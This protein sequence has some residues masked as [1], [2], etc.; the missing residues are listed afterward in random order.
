MQNKKELVSIVIDAHGGDNAPSEIVKGA[1]L[2]I[3]EHKNIKVILSGKQNVL[4]DELKRF[5]YDETRLE[6]LN[7][8]TVITNEEAPV[9]AIRSKRDSS[10]VIALDKLKKDDD[11][12]GF[13]SAGSTGA[14]LTGAFLKIGRLK[15]ISRPALAPILPTTNGGNTLL[16][17]CGANMDSTSQ[18]LLDF[19]IMGSFYMQAMY[20]IKKP[21]V[22]LLIVGVEEKKGN[23]LVKKTFPLMKELPINFVGNMEARDALSGKYDVIVSDGFSGN[24]L[25]KST[26]GAVSSMLKTL[27]SE[28]KTSKLS[29]RGSL[30]MRKTFKKLKVKLDHSNKGGS[31]FLG[32]KKIVIK[33]HGSSTAITIKT[34][35]EQVINLHTK[36][37]QQNLV[38]KIEQINKDKV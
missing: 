10:L 1:V 5:S 20:D 8:S 31:P 19:A 11:V 17:D 2:A 15:G 34:S 25:L 7:A 35:I 38:K 23:E 37:M 18:N 12:V 6:V 24:V 21:R 29:M 30:L 33:S 22:P 3:N 14:V 16:I 13:I 32:A 26:E 28:I 36:K 4:I 9:K 27:K